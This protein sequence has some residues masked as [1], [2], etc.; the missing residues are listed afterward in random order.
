V[1][2]TNPFPNIDKQWTELWG[3]NHLSKPVGPGPNRRGNAPSLKYVKS[4]RPGKVEPAN[5]MLK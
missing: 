2:T 4:L 3:G 1:T 5:L